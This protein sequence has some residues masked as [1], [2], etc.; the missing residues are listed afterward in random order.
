VW[1]S[2]VYHFLVRLSLLERTIFFVCLR[3]CENTH[4][5]KHT[6]GMRL[7]RDTNT[8]LSTNVCE[9]SAAAHACAA[10]LARCAAELPPNT[11]GQGGP[12]RIGSAPAHGS[13]QA[14]AT[15]LQRGARGRKR[16]ASLLSLVCLWPVKHPAVLLTCEEWAE[17]LARQVV[18]SSGSGMTR[19]EVRHQ[20]RCRHLLH[21]SKKQELQVGNHTLTNM[22]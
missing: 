10:S 14:H 4:V 20:C 5:Q 12:G 15:H 7:K 17:D 18:M 2:Q 1:M 3:V 8:C 22:P 16:T 13:V 21:P 19:A 11:A 9:T 6:S